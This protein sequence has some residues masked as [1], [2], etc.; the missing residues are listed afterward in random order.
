MPAA[1]YA[2]VEPARILAALHCPEE[3]AHNM[4]KFLAQAGGARGD[5]RDIARTAA[6][7]ARLRARLRD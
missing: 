5:L 6:E 7:I 2:A 4:L 1:R 3:G